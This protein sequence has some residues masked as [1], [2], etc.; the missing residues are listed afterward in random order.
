MLYIQLT[1][2]PELHTERFVLRRLQQADAPA[3]L[4]QRSDPRIMRYLDREPDTT[5]EQT[6]ALIER[7]TQNAA[8]NSGVTWGIVRPAATQELLGT[9]GLWRIMAEHHRAEVGYGLHPDYWQQGVMSEALAAV[10]DFGFQ[11]LK[12]HSVEANVNPHNT[13]SR[14]LL[15]KHGFVQEAYFRQNYFFRGQ[16]LDSIIY[17]LLTPEA[18]KPELINEAA[19]EL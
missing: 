13:A 6:T 4:D 12:L 18:A 15:E 2:F 7:I 10:L 1:P 14:R 17:S 8:D 16:F 3:L 19:T 9:I 11:T 5:L